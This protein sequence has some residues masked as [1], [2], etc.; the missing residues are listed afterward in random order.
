MTWSSY[1]SALGLALGLASCRAGPPSV[2][3]EAVERAREAFPAATPWSLEKGRELFSA[4]C[5]QCH[6]LPK[7]S[8]H[9]AE[10]WPG[11]AET[12][13]NLAGMNPREKRLLVQYLVAVSS[14]PANP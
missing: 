9:L 6:G 4:E 2:T 14:G 1:L 12:M 3:P 5:Q 7:P 13:G 8:S 11:I 10:A